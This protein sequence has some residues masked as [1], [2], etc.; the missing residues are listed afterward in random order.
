MIT[1]VRSKQVAGQGREEQPLP[2]YSGNVKKDITEWVMC[3][4]ALKDE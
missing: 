1:K 3:D 4:W 2:R